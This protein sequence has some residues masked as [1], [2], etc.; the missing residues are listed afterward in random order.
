MNNEFSKGSLDRT[1]CHTVPI[2]AI[3]FGAIV[4]IGLTFLFNLFTAGLGLT[5]YTENDT[6]Q[7]ILG[8]LSFIWMLVG[9]FIMLFIAGWITGKFARSQPERSCMEA[10]ALGFIMWSTYLLLSLIAVGNINVPVLTG[11]IGNYSSVVQSVNL[12]ISGLA[13]LGSF[14]V[15][16]MGAIGSCFGTCYGLKRS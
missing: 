13:T 7:V 8:I 15:I 16:L 4:A 5:L 6:G 3:I 12:N 11:L 1:T 9:G 2:A 14:F 10:T